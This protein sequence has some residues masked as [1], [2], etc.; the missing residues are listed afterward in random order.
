MKRLNQ[1]RFLHQTQAILQ[2]FLDSI[3]SFSSR[4]QGQFSNLVPLILS[5][6]FGQSS[7]SVIFGLPC[8]NQY[9]V[10]WRVFYSWFIAKGRTIGTDLLKTNNSNGY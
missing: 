10:F 1:A 4:V 7:E 6:I 5:L 9:I 3:A 8:L 2:Y